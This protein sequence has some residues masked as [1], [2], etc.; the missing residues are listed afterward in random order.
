MRFPY[1]LFYML[2]TSYADTL[3]SISDLGVKIKERKS[4]LGPS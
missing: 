3:L 2:G 4:I 1:K